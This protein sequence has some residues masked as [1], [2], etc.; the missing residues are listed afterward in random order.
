MLSS[1]KMFQSIRLALLAIAVAV[2]VSGLEAEAS[3]DIHS[4]LALKGLLGV[5]VVVEDFNDAE[6]GM[7][8]SEGTFQ[9]DVELKLRMA[10]IKV[11]TP[12]ERARIPGRP[13]LYLNVN[14]LEGGSRAFNVSLGLNQDVLLDRNKALVRGTPTWSVGTVGVGGVPFIRSVVRDEVDKFLNAWLSVNPK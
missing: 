1:R 8:F 9:T 3:D 7:G 10:G 13:Y 2:S 14:P 12:D 4:R 6:K 5:S 11:L